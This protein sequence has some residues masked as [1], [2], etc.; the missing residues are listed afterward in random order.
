MVGAD[1]GGL[2]APDGGFGGGG[3][4]LDGRGAAD[5][6]AVVGRD[7]G[8]EVVVPVCVFGDVRVR[9]LLDQGVGVADWWGSRGGCEGEGRGEE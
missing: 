3:E 8:G 9:A 7:G 6:D 2:A 4:T 1:A 5:D